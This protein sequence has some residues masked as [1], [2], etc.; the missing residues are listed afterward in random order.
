[1]K[2]ED[3][4]EVENIKMTRHF[5]SFI[6]LNV[7]LKQDSRDK[8]LAMSF[9]RRKLA[10]DYRLLSPED[11]EFFLVFMGILSSGGARY[12]RKIAPESIFKRESPVLVS[13]I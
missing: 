11:H 6:L 7:S 10:K 8:E 5:A 9:C 13:Q 4:Q 2:A 3:N 1:M 12:H